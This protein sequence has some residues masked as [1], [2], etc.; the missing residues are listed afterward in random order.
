MSR[1][2]SC[3]NVKPSDARV[4]VDLDIKGIHVTINS[5]FK[6]LFGTHMKQAVMSVLEE[7]GIQDIHI[8]VEDDGALDFVIR[9]RLKTAI[10]RAK[11]YE[12]A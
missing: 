12:K 4:H 9:A 7:E 6:E 11:G 2:G 1:Q 3:G 8:T 10:R 5:K